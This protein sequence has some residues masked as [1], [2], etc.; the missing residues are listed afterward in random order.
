MFRHWGAGFGD[1]GIG[2]GEATLAADA[3]WTLF[4]VPG[5]VGQSSQFRSAA[6]RETSG[7]VG[8]IPHPIGFGVW[9]L[10]FGV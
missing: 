5:S 2:R 10:G 3:P 8:S 7:I 9:G 4:P 6:A 1:K